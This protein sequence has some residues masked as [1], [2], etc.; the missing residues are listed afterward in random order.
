[1]A[2]AVLKRKIMFD[3]EIENISQ[4]TDVYSDT[5]VIRG[6]EW[7]FKIEKIVAC[8]EKNQMEDKIGVQLQCNIPDKLND[9][10]CGALAKIKLV[11]FKDDKKSTLKCISEVF[12]KEK[13][14]WYTPSFIGWKEL[15]DNGCARDD[16]ILFEIELRVGRLELADCSSLTIKTIEDEYKGKEVTAKLMQLTL[17]KIDESF[18]AAKS[19]KF[20]FNGLLWHIDIGRVI[21]NKQDYLDIIL[22]FDNKS[23]PDDWSC[24]LS[25][26]L[27]PFVGKSNGK[28]FVKLTKNRRRGAEITW[29]RSVGNGTFEIMLKLEVKESTSAALYLVNEVNNDTIKAN[30][31]GE[32]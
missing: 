14:E 27:N 18:M 15:I 21:K 7:K 29:P 23:V 6:F 30:L 24:E 19:S 26:T 2:Q 11:S 16:T 22:S 3:M 10:M 28:H 1:M 32:I 4:L 25:A 5:F 20:K 12:D 17:N 8:E 13:T 31:K 9:Y